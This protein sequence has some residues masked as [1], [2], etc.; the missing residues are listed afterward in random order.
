MASA[1]LNPLMVLLTTVFGFFHSDDL[2]MLVFDNDP[3]LFGLDLALFAHV[4]NIATSIG[5]GVLKL[6]TNSALTE[7][8][9]F[10]RAIAHLVEVLSYTLVAITLLE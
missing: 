8:S 5:I 1:A 6:V 4:P 9:S 2:F 10:L 7:W 3:V